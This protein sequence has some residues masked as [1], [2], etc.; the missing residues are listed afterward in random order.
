MLNKN[1]MMNSRK[2]MVDVILFSLISN[3]FIL[4]GIAIFALILIL[5]FYFML[6]KIAGAFMLIFGLYFLSK[7]WRIGA[8]IILL[9]V[10]LFFNPFG[11]STLAIMW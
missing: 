10:I 3:P 1:Q 2:G 8:G 11:W 5:M 7:D 9:A 4:L 6:G